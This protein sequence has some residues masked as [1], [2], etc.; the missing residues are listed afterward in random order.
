VTDDQAAGR[1]SGGAS[2]S[3]SAASTGPQRTLAFSASSG[4]ARV[5]PTLSAAIGLP[6]AAAHSQ[7]R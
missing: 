5:R 3:A 1:V 6:A 2:R 4:S 7:K